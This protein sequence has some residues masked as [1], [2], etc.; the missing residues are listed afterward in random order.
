MADRIAE[1]ERLIQ[2]IG[3]QTDVALALGWLASEL[4]DEKAQRMRLE[5]TVNGM[6]QLFIKAGEYQGRERKRRLP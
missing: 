2:R 5:R 1:V 6:Q 4:E 3:P